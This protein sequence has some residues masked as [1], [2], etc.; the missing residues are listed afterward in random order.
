MKKKISF[1]ELV[2]SFLDTFI[3]N[4]AMSV[5][6]LILLYFSC[7]CKIPYWNFFKTE[8][9]FFTTNAANF[10]VLYATT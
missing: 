5:E 2:F 9:F 8:F 4:K 3:I 10:E 6:R 7:S 1:S